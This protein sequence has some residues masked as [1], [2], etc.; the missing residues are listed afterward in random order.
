MSPVPRISFA[1][2][3]DK[4]GVVELLDF[5]TLERIRVDQ[6]AMRMSIEHLAWSDECT[7]FCYVELGG[8]LTIVQLESRDSRLTS[9]LEILLSLCFFQAQRLYCWYRMENLRIHQRTMPLHGLAAQVSNI[10]NSAWPNESIEAG[11]SPCLGGNRE[12]DYLCGQSNDQ[13]EQ[14]SSQISS[15]P[16]PPGFVATSISSASHDIETPTAR[17]LGLLIGDASLDIG[18]L[19]SMDFEF[20]EFD[21][22]GNSIVQTPL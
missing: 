2:C 11:Q 14:S 5:D 10:L 6:I 16:V 8:R 18:T 3:G 20:G 4:E 19:H 22:F 17:W 12:R 1:G 9:T 13:Q 15:Y 7:R 21:I